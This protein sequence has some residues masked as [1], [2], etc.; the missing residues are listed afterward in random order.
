MK[1]KTFNAYKKCILLIAKEKYKNI[2]NRKF[3]LDY[4]LTNFILVLKHVT[5]WE[6]VL[7][8]TNDNTIMKYHWKTIYNEFNK[9]TK[10]GIF[11][12]AFE[13]FLKNNYFKISKVRQNKNIKMLID[14]TKINN[15]KGSECNVIN[16]E[17]KKKNI[18][19]IVLIC[20][21]NKLPIGVTNMK[22]KNVYKNGNKTCNHDVKGIQDALDTIPFEIPSYVTIHLIGDKGYI[23]QNKFTVGKHVIQITTPKRKNQKNKNT[24]K[25]FKILQKRYRIENLFA[26]IKS[27]NRIN[28][29]METNLNNYFSFLYLTLLE[30]YFNYIDKNNIQL[31]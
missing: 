14:V 8:N 20:D 1:D 10:D 12:K 24:K 4:Y 18:T 23:T 17:Y 3:C 7:I 11:K 28:T 5:K 30:I 16:N 6:S 26:S 22:V 21:E 2:R 15:K 27:N 29:R 19:P 25:E 31:V 9:W 13:S